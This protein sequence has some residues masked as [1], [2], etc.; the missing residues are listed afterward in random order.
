RTIVHGVEPHPRDAPNHHTGN[1][2]LGALGKAGGI[3]ETRIQ[4][5][6]VAIAVVNTQATDLN[7]QEAQRENPRQHERADAD[8]NGTNSHDQPTPN[9]TAV[10]RKSMARMASDEYTTV[11]VVAALMPSEVGTAS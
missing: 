4:L 5:V 3:A 11:R 6:R 9:I 7:R 1:R 8:F 2:D 10:S